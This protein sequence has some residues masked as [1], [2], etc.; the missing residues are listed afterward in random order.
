MERFDMTGTNS[1]RVALG[2]H[3]RVKADPKYASTL[4]RVKYAKAEERD[5]KNAYAR[6]LAAIPFDGA[7]VAEAVSRLTSA[8]KDLKEATAAMD[9]LWAQSDISA[10]T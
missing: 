7:A 10:M 5:A 2:A 9:K 1:R 3:Q 6:S 4:Q 8:V